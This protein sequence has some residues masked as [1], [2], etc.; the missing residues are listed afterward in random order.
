[1]NGHRQRLRDRFHDFGP[2]SMKDHEL[3]ELLLFFSIPRQNTNPIAHALL[4][5]FGSLYGTLTA[6]EIDLCSV[7]GVGENTALLLR[8]VNEIARR[9]RAN[10]I[11]KKPLANLK[12]LFAYCRELLLGER[13][14]QFFVVLL[15]ARFNLIRAVRLSVGIP[16][17][18]TVYPRLIAE[19]ALKAGAVKAV[20]VHNHP[21]GNC[22]PSPEDLQTTESVSAALSALGIELVEHIIV[23]DSEA[24]AIKAKTFWKENESG[25]DESHKPCLSPVTVVDYLR[26]LDDE[27]LDQIIAML[28]NAPEE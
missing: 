4:Q 8:L 11:V 18:V 28:E 1:M 14:E 17:S 19:Q 22:T 9:A 26:T 16:D 2:D 20:M 24:C 23:S 3:L 25:M 12:D 10:A 21:A 6:S 5:R 13:S 27:Q 7:E 15:D